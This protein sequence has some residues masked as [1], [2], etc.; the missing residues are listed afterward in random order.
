MK[1]GTDSNGGKGW[2]WYEVTSTTDGSKP[3][4][5]GNGVPLCLGCHAARK[6]ANPIYLPVDPGRVDLDTPIGA[7]GIS[8]C[9]SL[10]LSRY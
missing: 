10:A 1:T 9:P 2:F 5:T 3:V 4:A 7:S 8:T 6:P